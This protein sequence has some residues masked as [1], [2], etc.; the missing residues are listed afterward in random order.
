MEKVS[1]GWHV[2]Y[3]QYQHEKKI[4]LSL[5]EIGIDSFLPLITTIRKWCDR[6]KQIHTPLF[7]TYIFVKIKSSKDISKCLAIKSVYKFLQFDGKYAIVN[8]RE[9]LFIKQFLNLEG[10][11]NI[12]TTQSLPKVGD[13][14]MI[15]YGFLKGLSCTVIKSKNVNRIFVKLDSLNQN[16]T[17][18]IPAR[19]LTLIRNSA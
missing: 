16:I 10:V 13:S 14:I 7:P 4:V 6:K 12:T 19:H 1:K 3:V 15:N 17:A 9:I 2:L 18:T 5:K 8:E 11:E